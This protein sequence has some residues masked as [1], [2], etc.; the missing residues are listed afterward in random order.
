V[1]AVL[2][3]VAGPPGRDSRTLRAIPAF[4]DGGEGVLWKDFQAIALQNRTGRSEPE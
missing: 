1:D 4:A 3:P 2:Q